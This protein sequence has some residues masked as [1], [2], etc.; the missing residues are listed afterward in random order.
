[1]KKYKGNNIIS[2]YREN[3]NL[4]NY[5]R[6]ELVHILVKFLLDNKIWMSKKPFETLANLIIE[7]FPS[8]IIDYYYGTTSKGN[9]KGKLNSR[10][11]NQMSL[12][13]RHSLMDHKNKVLKKNDSENITSNWTRY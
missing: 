1:M 6:K 5:L 13:R 12:L 11:N 10:Y 8:E 9:C 3:K 2:F 4:T 7:E